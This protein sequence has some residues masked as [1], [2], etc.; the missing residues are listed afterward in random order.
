[1]VTKLVGIFTKK[2]HVSNKISCELKKQQKCMP[3][4]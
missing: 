1:M 3:V 2:K 4:K